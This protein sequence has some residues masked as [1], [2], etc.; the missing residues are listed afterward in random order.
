MS[1]SDESVCL[2]PGL[3]LPTVEEDP[4]QYLSE[5]FSGTAIEP[6]QIVDYGTFVVALVAFDVA[7]GN[8]VSAMPLRDDLRKLR[9]EGYGPSSTQLQHFPG[10]VSGFRQEL[11]FILV[12]TAR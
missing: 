2:P 4:Q 5:N 8:R 11:A 6:W 9:L 10:G 12:V 3:Y 7:A 1:N